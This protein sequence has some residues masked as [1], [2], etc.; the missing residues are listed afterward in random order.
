MSQSGTPRKRRR[1]GES[2][3]QLDESVLRAKYLD[4]CSARVADVLLRLTADE[5]YLL[6][7]DAARDSGLQDTSD[8]SYEQIVQLATERLSRRLS[9]PP[10]ET[11]VEAY[12]EDPRHFEEELLGLWESEPSRPEPPETNGS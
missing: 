4:Y 9:I 3:E 5:M 11:W 1:P 6:A 8:L 12:R 10:F 2:P 7:Q